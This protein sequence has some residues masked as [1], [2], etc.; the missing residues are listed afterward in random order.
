M[1]NCISK[2]LS[3]EAP[4]PRANFP[5]PNCAFTKI[6]I[7]PS[8]KH[9]IFLGSWGRV[10]PRTKWG[11]RGSG[12]PLGL[13]NFGW[14]SDGDFEKGSKMIVLEGFL[15]ISSQK[16]KPAGFM[17]FPLVSSWAGYLYRELCPGHQFGSEAGVL[18]TDFT[19]VSPAESR[20]ANALT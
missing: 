3:A 13:E 12:P 15:G 5:H 11:R 4:P 6:F 18:G 14:W 19:K 20:M 8:A 17:S 9:R 7:F 2:F 16:S 1:F 10:P